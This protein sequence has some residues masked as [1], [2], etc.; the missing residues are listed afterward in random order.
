MERKPGFI[1]GLP[2]RDV[3]RSVLCHYLKHIQ[4]LHEHDDSIAIYLDSRIVRYHTYRLR[5]RRRRPIDFNFCDSNGSD[6]LARMGPGSGSDGLCLLCPLRQAICR[7]TGILQL[8]RFAVCVVAFSDHH[9][10]GSQHSILLFGERLQWI[11]QSLL[12]RSLHCDTGCSGLAPVWADLVGQASRIEAHNRTPRSRTPRSSEPDGPGSNRSRSALA[13]GCVLSRPQS[14]FGRAHV[15]I[16]ERV[17]ANLLHQGSLTNRLMRTRPSPV[18]PPK[19]VAYPVKPCP[20]HP[21]NRFGT[22]ARA[23]PREA[24]R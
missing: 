6:G 21:W 15:S 16:E 17:D 13:G 12:Q 24:T 14:Q 2:G 4:V 11:E 1:L 8:R 23:R 7:A 10:A 19:A 3:P 5:R 9:R 20:N 18:V 22:L